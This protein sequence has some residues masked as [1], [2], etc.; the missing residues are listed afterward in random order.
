MPQTDHDRVIA[1]AGLFQAIGL[2]RDLAHHGRSEPTAL[3]S[4]LA[5]LLKTDAA[6]SADV[7]GGVAGLRYG[8]RWLRDYLLAPRDRDLTR[9]LINL[10]VLERKLRKR[11][12]L[13]HQLREGIEAS[14][15]RLDHLTLPHPTMV[16]SFAQLYSATISTLA[17]RIMV[18]GEPAY[19]NDEDNQNTIRALLLAGIR[20]AILWQQSGGGR[21]TL[22]FRRRALLQECQRLLATLNGAD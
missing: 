1:L 22:L 10:L 9:Y 11:S 12:D 20:A 14:N 4:S 3:H 13:L 19:L 21:L 16:A 6:S 7:Y 8:L 5:S 15:R 2:V 17:P 18:S